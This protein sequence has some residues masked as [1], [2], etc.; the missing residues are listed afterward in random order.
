MKKP[1]AVVMIIYRKEGCCFTTLKLKNHLKN[2]RDS[3]EKA[4]VYYMDIF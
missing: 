2:M 4:T 1:A 3:R